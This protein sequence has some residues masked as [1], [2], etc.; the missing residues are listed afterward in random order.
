VHVNGSRVRWSW[1]ADGDLVR[2]GLFTMVLRYDRRP[3]GIA[4]EDVPLEAGAFPPEPPDEARGLRLA[5]TED[6]GTELALR[7]QP[8]PPVLSRP[9]RVPKVAAAEMPA[10]PPGEWEPVAGPGQGYYAIWQQQMQLMEAFHNDMAMMVQMFVAMHREFQGSVRDELTRVQQL[11]RELGRLNA[12]LGQLP[13]SPGAAPAPEAAR[14]ETKDRPVRRPSQSGP[15]ASPRVQAAPPEESAAG[16]RPSRRKAEPDRAAS[17][18]ADRSQPPA[19]PAP[20][21]EST[22]MYADLTRRITELQRERRGYWQRILKA[23]GG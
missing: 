15:D 14:P 9:P 18:A 10:V 17:P 11:T 20:R 2:F 6:P 22:E 12:R 16:R 19:G 5:A 7:P 13:E 8:R 23:I 4:R 3:D 21:M 1:L